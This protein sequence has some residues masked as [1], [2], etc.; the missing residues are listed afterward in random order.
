MTQGQITDEHFSCLCEFTQLAAITRRPYQLQ[1]T[2]QLLQQLLLHVHSS[3]YKYLCL[4]TLLSDSTLTML[5]TEAVWLQFAMQVF[6]MQWV[7]LFEEMG[8]KVQIGTKE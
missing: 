5:P 2:Q 8:L 1:N 7:T 6:G 3:S 4:V